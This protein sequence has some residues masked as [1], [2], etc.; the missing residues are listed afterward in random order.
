MTSKDILKLYHK[1]GLNNNIRDAFVKEIV[2]SQYAFTKEIID[3]IEFEKGMT[4]EE[5]NN[6]KTNFTYR[7]LGK[8]HTTFNTVSS[9]LKRKKD[10]WEK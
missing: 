6:L 3:K 5:F 9:I 2:E 4:Q 10:K 7:Y 8:L 1:I